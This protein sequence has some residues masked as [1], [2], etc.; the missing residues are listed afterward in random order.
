MC[1]IDLIVYICAKSLQ[2][3]KSGPGRAK[4]FTQRVQWV[5]ICKLFIFCAQDTFQHIAH[6]LRRAKF[7]QCAQVVHGSLQQSL[8]DVQ[9]IC[10]CCCIVHIIQ[11]IYTSSARELS[12]EPVRCAINI[13]AHIATLFTLYKIFAQVVQGSFQQRGECDGNLGKMKQLVVHF[14]QC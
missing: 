2:L 14:A 4:D 8:Y 12:T 6:I 9:Y 3:Q 1:T 13:F 11:N 7:V 10:T 5:N